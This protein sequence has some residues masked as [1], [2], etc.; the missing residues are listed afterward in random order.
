LFSSHPET[1]LEDV[2]TVLLQV[3][4]DEFEVAVD[5]ESAF[6]T[7]E[8]VMRL[9]AACGRGL[10]AEVEQLRQRWV[11]RGGRGEVGFQKVE[12]GDDDQDTDGDSVDEESDSGDEEMGDAPPAPRQR[13]EPEVDEDGFTTVPNRRKR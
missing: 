10:F 2:E 4:L 8:T 13:A 1:D 5:D 6:E 7:A 12:T 9:R 11:A 3:M